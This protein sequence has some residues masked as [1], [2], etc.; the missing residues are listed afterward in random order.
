M[1][2]RL[3]MQGRKAWFKSYSSGRRRARL[4][5]LDLVARGMGVPALRPPSHGG[6]EEA[7]EIE[8]RR[9]HELA[10]TGI[11][12]PEVLAESAQALLLSDIGETFSSVLA[13]VEQNARLRLITRAASALAHAHAKDSYIG[14]PLARN[15]TIAAD[16][17]IGFIDFEEDPHEVMSLQQAQVRDW[18]FFTVGVSRYFEQQEDVLAAII[19]DAM[20]DASPSVQE[21]LVVTAQRLSWVGRLAAF[22]GGRARRIASAIKA[23]KLT[24]LVGALLLALLFGLGVDFASDGDVDSVRVLVGWVD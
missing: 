4:R 20:R 18:L 17:R 24:N 23:L 13:R 2:T 22:L 5:L 19:A 11:R 10:A 9:L 21:A 14:Q 3:D 1:V 16:G 15:I 6:G 8:A 7:C 12:V